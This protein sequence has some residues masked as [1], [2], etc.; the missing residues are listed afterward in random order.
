MEGKGIAEALRVALIVMNRPDVV[1]QSLVRGRSPDAV[2]IKTLIE[3]KPLV[4]RFIIL[5][6]RCTLQIV[7]YA[8]Q[9]MIPHGR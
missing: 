9:R 1:L 6:G 2:R 7:P 5:A 8:Y 4:I 3:H